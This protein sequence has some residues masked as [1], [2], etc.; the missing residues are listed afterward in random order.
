MEQKKDILK[1]ITRYAQTGEWEKVL[2]EYEKLLA[3]EPDDI[4]THNSM[5]DALVKLG[6]ER[7]A[8][9]HYK[10]VYEDH[11]KKGN[12]AKL[13]FLQKKIAKLDCSRFDPES[14]SFCEK[15]SKTVD[16]QSSYNTQDFSNAIP[17]LKELIK[18]DKYNVELLYKLADACE[19][20]LMVG[21]AVEAY[22]RAVRI[23][24]EKGNHAEAVNLAKKI[25]ELEKGNTE[26]MSVMAEDLAVSG[27][28]EEAEEMFKELLINLAEKN[29]VAQGRIVAKRAMEHKSEYGKQF[30]AYFLFK[31]NE[32]LEAKKVLEGSYELSPEEKV[33][34]GKIYYKTAEYSAAKTVLMSLDS[35]VINENSEI[36]EQIGDI[37]L[38][39]REH[40]QAEDYYLR[41]MRILIEAQEQDQA[42]SLANKVK[43]VNAQN[44][45]AHETLSSIYLK[46]GLKNQLIDEYTLLIPL[47]EKAGRSDDASHTR[48]LQAKIKLL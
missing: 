34:L 47:Y 35:E 19:K 2:K 17:A 14:K 46:K 12:I 28:K 7:K 39:L 45:E 24:L 25:L 27:K 13:S 10:K 33:L 16:A 22:V 26:A 8:L 3:M 44:I 23:L 4:N 11:Q 40:R 6:R 48:Q 36:L 5:G 37:L 18:T 42:L 41:A 1:T 21:D 38:K 32:I 20:Q 29:A 43:N 30:Y 15:M 31:D 9:D